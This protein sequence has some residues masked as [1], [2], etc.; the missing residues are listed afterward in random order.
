ME[1]EFERRE[2]I[3]VGWLILCVRKRLMAGGMGLK[4]GCGLGRAKGFDRF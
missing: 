3:G 1:D 4:K 2:L